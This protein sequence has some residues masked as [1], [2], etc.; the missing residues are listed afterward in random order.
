MGEIKEKK[1]T[2]IQ[3]VERCMLYMVFGYVVAKAIGVLL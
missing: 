3:V 2:L 1:Y